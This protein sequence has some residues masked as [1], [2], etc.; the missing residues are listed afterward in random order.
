MFTSESGLQILLTSDKQF[1]AY[2]VSIWF[3]KKWPFNLTIEL[4]I[5]DH[6]WVSLIEKVKIDYSSIQIEIRIE[7]PELHIKEKTK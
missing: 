3:I 5:R 1:N 7:N 2:R 6:R 4:E